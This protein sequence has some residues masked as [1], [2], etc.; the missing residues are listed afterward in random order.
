MT[1]ILGAAGFG[2]NPTFMALSEDI[3]SQNPMKPA[4]LPPKRVQHAT[5]L[6]DFLDKTVVAVGAGY[7]LPMANVWP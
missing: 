3:I 5:C 2:W 4:F 1:H 7:I 6:T